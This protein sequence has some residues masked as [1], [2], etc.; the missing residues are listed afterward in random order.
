MNTFQY[1]GD[2][3]SV[4]HLGPITVGYEFTMYTT[5]EGEGSVELCAV[6]YEPITGVAP[7]DFVIS[8]TT[9]SGTAGMML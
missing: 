1:Y 7:R 2:N 9:S 6:I 4:T 3:I 5:S 8:S